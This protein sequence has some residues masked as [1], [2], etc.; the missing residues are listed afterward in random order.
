M[1]F[2]SGTN[3]SVV[4]VTEDFY[5]WREWYRKRV[6]FYKLEDAFKRVR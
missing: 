3:C 4:D 1:S 6:S 2:M 5:L